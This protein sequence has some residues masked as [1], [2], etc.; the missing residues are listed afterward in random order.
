MDAAVD[1]HAATRPLELLGISAIE[2]RAYR[3]LLERHTAT[4]ADIAACLEITRGVAR[5]LLADLEALGLATHTP[6]V[7]RV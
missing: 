7:P 6:K 1:R 2:E 5:R 3:M 4:V